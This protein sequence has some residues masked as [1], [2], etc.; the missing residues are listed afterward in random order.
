MIMFSFAGLPVFVHMLGGVGIIEF[1]LGVYDEHLGLNA[2][3]YTH[4]HTLG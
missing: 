3:K 4:T 1:F 2:F